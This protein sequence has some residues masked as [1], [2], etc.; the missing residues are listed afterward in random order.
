M[1]VFAKIVE[2]VMMFSTTAT[3]VDGN[4]CVSAIFGLFLLLFNL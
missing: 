2:T 4:N 3:E 1:E